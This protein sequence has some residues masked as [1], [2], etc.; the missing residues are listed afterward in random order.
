MFKSYLLL[1]PAGSVLLL[2]KF[3]QT[4]REQKDEKGKIFE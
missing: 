1:E 2:I 4:Q 3:H